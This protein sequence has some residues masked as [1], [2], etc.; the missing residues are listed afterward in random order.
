LPAAIAVLDKVAMIASAFGPGASF[1][2]VPDPRSVD[3]S[4]RCGWLHAT[5]TM[6]TS[7]DLLEACAAFQRP[8]PYGDVPS[9]PW[10]RVTPHLHTIDSARERLRAWAEDAWAAEEAQHDR[11]GRLIDGVIVKDP[12]RPNPFAREEATVS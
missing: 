7:S 5:A 6:C 1:P 10:L 12:P 9:S 3:P 11:G 2:A 4:V 8:H